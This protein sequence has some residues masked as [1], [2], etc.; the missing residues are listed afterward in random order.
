MNTLFSMIS[1]GLALA[2]VQARAYE[3]RYDDIVHHSQC[4]Y[5]GGCVDA[6]RVLCSSSETSWVR[7][8][9]RDRVDG[10]SNNFTVSAISIGGAQAVLGVADV[11]RSFDDE[12]FKFSCPAWVGR[13][14]VVGSV[15]SL[16]MVRSWTTSDYSRTV[17]PAY[18]VE[19]ACVDPSGTETGDPIVTLY[20]DH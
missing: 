5:S 8:R 20:Q 13:Y 15:T 12:S 1:L 14:D 19:F 2:A 10:Y 4:A 17:P 7:A 9:V 18:V 3:I 16:A 11:E 6:W